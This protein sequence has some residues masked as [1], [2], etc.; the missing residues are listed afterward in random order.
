MRARLLLLFMICLAWMATAQ[1]NP[2]D[3]NHRLP[4]S[5]QQS[6]DQATTKKTATLE[7][8]PIQQ[9]E[10]PVE[11]SSNTPLSEQQTTQDT[12]AQSGNVGEQIL[13]NRRDYFSSVRS[14]QVFHYWYFPVLTLFLAFIINIDRG[15]ITKL[16]KSVTNLN[17]LNLL[18]RDQRNRYR[19]QYILFGIL[20]VLSAAFFVKHAVG[21]LWDID[22]SILR[23]S[24][25]I[26]G[27][28]L[29]RHLVMAVISFAFP[30]N[31]EIN[32]Y[33]YSIF[34]FNIIL[35]IGLLLIN[36]FLAFS[37]PKIAQSCVYLGLALFIIQ[38]G[39]RSARGLLL[40][41]NLI[42]RNKFRFFMYICTLEIAPIFLI[43]SIFRQF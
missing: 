33:S 24:L 8:A 18:Y 20:S 26:G 38:Y 19:P 28:Y 36:L 7:A 14:N 4:K 30:N 13:E 17:Y 43:I 31:S 42:Y 10:H 39:Y 41:A 9:A 34:I 12:I 22:L 25:V 1:Q 16:F 2:F 3:L 40:S 21:Y 27:I 15:S 6:T 5:E 37:P 32:Q 29:I 35:G 23:S 11:N